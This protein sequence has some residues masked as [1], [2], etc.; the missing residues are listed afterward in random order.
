ML[1][2]TVYDADVAQ[3]IDVTEQIQSIQIT[4]K[5]DAV[6]TMR[7]DV[8]GLTATHAFD[9]VTVSYT[10]GA[11]FSGIIQSQSDSLRGGSQ[12][13]RFSTWETKD[14]TL[15]LENRI[16]NR[17]YTDSSVESIIASL[18][19]EYPCGITGN[20]VRA[21]NK[22]VEQIAFRY[23]TLLAAIKQLAEITG[24]RWFV[25]ADKDLHFF[26]TDEG[27]DSTVF[28]TSTTGGLLRNIQSGSIELAS[29]ID[30]RT[31]NR[32]W[33]IGARTASATMNTQSFTQS[34]ERIFKLGFT[35]RNYQVFEN[36]VLVDSQYIKLDTSENE[37]N[38]NTK[39]LINLPNQVL[40]IPDSRQPLVVNGVHTLKIT[41]NPEVQIADYFEDPSSIV[42]NGIYEKAILDKD[43][44]E[45]LAAR[46]RGRAELRRRSTEN[47]TITFDT[48][49]MSVHRGKKYRLV[50]PEL[51]IDSYWLCIGVSTTISAPEAANIIKS[52]ELEEVM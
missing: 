8:R 42:I 21:T 34:G 6:S 38:V 13:N 17:I 19:I 18:L 49:E 22:I 44:N 7:A 37:A 32:V 43:I 50:I 48:R 16:I 31:A 3:T 41:Y 40:R 23:I 29:E 36:G 45:K 4:A 51:N 5:M 10:G 39:Y 24:W 25:D 33:V 2:V 20:H 15:R 9:D 1:N 12:L 46:Q 26:D 52:I 35:P 14:S 30:D 27:V 11:L 47:R 28:S